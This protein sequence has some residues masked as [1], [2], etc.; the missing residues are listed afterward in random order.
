MF[1]QNKSNRLD[2]VDAIRGFAIVSIMLL[3]NLE[4]FDVYFLPENL[5]AWMVDLD[6]II[7]EVSFFL[8]AGKSYAIFAAVGFFLIP[9]A[10]LN[11]RL[12]FC[13]A[14]ILLLQP[15]EFIR[16]IKALELPNIEL[17]DPESWMYFGK[18]SEYIKDSSFLNTVYGN[19]T[20]GKIAVFKWSDE[21]GRF[22]HILSLFM[23]GMLAGRKKL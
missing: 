3:H 17:S 13:I 20:N 14:I 15:L 12:V 1:L 10:N 23:F 16:L 8:F 4:H 11:N 5:P 2:V 9:V 21:N 7:W 18:M 19:L 6:K 22:F